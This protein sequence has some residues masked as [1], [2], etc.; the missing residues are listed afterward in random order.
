MISTQDR[1]TARQLT[2]DITAT[3]HGRRNP[4]VWGTLFP[5]FWD[6]GGTGGTIKISPHFRDPGYRGYN[7]NDFPGD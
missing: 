5:H 4:G 3:S 2:V 1:F 7:E 6:L